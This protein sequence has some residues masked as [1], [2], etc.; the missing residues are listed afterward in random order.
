MPSRAELSRAHRFRFRRLVHAA[1]AGRLDD[2][3][4]RIGA[5]VVAGVVMSAV[6]VAGLAVRAAMTRPPR[7]QRPDVVIVERETGSEYVYR[8]GQLHGVPN[9]TSA[10][11]AIGS[12]API[13]AVSAASLHGVPLGAPW[14]V[15]GL[16]ARLPARSDLATAWSVCSVDGAARIRFGPLSGGR[17]LGDRGVVVAPSG[18]GPR[19]LITSGAARRPPPGRGPVMVAPE[20]L[21]AIPADPQVPSAR[22]YLTAPGALCARRDGNGIAVVV[23]ADPPPVP[24][25]VV[26]GSG[27]VIASGADPAVSWLVSDAGIRYRLD[28]DRAAA[29]L[30]VSGVSP[31]LL[32]PAVLALIPEGPRLSAIDVTPDAG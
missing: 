4:P 5:A 24:V 2:P 9:L 23:G 1:C 11:L 30:G 12:A 14:G 8:D 22:R 26:A 32:P 19:T 16:P 7:W 28:G 27:A 6:I 3:P 18:G 21:A 13:V 15:D 10:R 29:S 17:R 31:L 25:S 20:F